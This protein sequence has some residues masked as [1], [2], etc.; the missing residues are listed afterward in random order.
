M[1]R[2]RGREWRAM[3]KKGERW[4]QRGEGEGEEVLEE[5]RTKAFRTEKMEERTCKQ[6]EIFFPFVG[7]HP[8][9][10]E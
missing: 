1:S 10:L 9:L 3:V 5:E 4:D 2:R 6:T 7:S 8:A